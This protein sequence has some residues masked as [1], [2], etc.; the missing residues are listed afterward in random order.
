MMIDKPF[1]QRYREQIMLPFAISQSHNKMF[2]QQHFTL[3]ER[4]ESI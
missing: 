4:S 2:H 3:D 1:K